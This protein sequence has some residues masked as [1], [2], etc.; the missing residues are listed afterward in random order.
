MGI[1]TI[2]IYPLQFQRNAGK[3]GTCLRGAIDVIGI[4][5]GTL[6]YVTLE[7]VQN[8][9][10]SRTYLKAI[11]FIQVN[12]VG[13]SETKV[14][15]SGSLDFLILLYIA[16]QMRNQHRAGEFTPRPHR[17]SAFP[18]HGASWFDAGLDKCDAV[19]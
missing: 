8:I 11:M 15:E 3:I 16:L 7:L 10:H 14:P 4:A 6:V 1:F 2:L 18:A 13:Q 12:I 9:L 19:V 17:M 5:V